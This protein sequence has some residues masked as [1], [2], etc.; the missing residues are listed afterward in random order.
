MSDDDEDEDYDNEEEEDEDLDHTP[1]NARRQPASRQSFTTLSSEGVVSEEDTPSDRSGA[2]GLRRRSHSEGGDDKEEESGNTTGG[3]ASGSG[4]LL[5]TGSAEN[6]QAE[7][8]KCTCI[9]D[10]LS[11]KEKTVRRM[12]V[13]VNSPDRVFDV[14]EV[15]S[16]LKC[17]HISS[18]ESEC[19]F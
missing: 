3:D 14:S 5:S 18:F 19:Y 7:L 16:S 2:G 8:T 11:D 15:A 13:K 4:G 1:T 10:G 6:L 9:S 17:L 12:R